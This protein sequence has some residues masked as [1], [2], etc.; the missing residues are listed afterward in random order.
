[1]ILLSHIYLVS[2]IS[3]CLC[4]EKKKI[5]HIVIESLAWQQ[6][7]YKYLSAK[8]MA[9]QM[10]TTSRFPPGNV[11]SL[12]V[13][14]FSISE[15]KVPHCAEQEDEIWMRRRTGEEARTDII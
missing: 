10:L 3:V 6:V 13:E 7:E 5:L 8:K 9:F 2:W 14:S 4:N 1:M 11:T 15:H 12:S